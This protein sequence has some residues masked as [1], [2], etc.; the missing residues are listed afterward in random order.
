M[1][2]RL[3]ILVI[4]LA[5]AI[6]L[7]GVFRI[8]HAKVNIKNPMSKITQ[9]AR[10]TPAPKLLP[11]KTTLFVPYWTLGK[12]LPLTYNTISYF[13]ITADANGINMK[14]SGYKNLPVFSR[15]VGQNQSTFLVVRLLESEVNEKILSDNNFRK[16]IIEESI[17]SA[18]KYGFEG[19]MLDFEYN[20][21]AFDSIVRQITKLSQDF[22]IRVHADN[23]QFYQTLYGDTFYRARPFDVEAI[24]KEADGIFVM[25]YDFHKANGDPGPNF[26]LSALPDEDYSF[27]QMVTDFTNKV[28]AQKITILFGLFGYDWTLNNKN[29]SL[30]QASTLTTNEAETKFISSCVLKNCKVSRDK[31]AAEEH[32]TY[33]D[34]D[35]REHEVWFEDMASVAKKQDFLKTKGITSTGFWAWSYF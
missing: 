28:E 25:A 14:D 16:K 23:L 15:L 32:V 18:K 1:K 20:A 19:I 13:G 7:L 11:A 34:S 3:G 35:G 2:Q 4:F 6:T 8:F 26:P 31:T 22:A 30:G 10:P 27:Y 21:L 12:N 17:S 33:T 9:E 29:H 24:G 5:L